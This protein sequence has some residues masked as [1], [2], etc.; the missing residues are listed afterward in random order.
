MACKAEFADS[1]E[2]EEF[3]YSSEFVDSSDSSDS[4]K[5]VEYMES[6]KS[7]TLCESIP[8]GRTPQANC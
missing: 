6:R 1:T 7:M 3:F 4:T 5:F 8:N 2:S